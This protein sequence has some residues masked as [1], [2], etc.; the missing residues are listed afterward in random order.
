MIADVFTSAW[1]YWAVAI[2][3][4]LPI[5]MVVL[6]EW[7]HALRRRQSY[8]VRPVTVLRNYLLPLGAL[9]LLLTEARQVPAGA[10]SVRTV[11][12]LFAFVVLI[13]LL[14]GVNATLFQGRPRG[15]GAS[16]CRRSSSTSP[17]SS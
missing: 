11:A 3:V 6:T 7:Q 8:L 13:L 17:G 1:F 16:A 9:L 4:G 10:T 12:T 15:R 2:A 5:G 14:S